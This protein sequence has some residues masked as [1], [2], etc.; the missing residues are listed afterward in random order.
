M[1]FQYTHRVLLPIFLSFF[2]SA[3]EQAKNSA[4]HTARELTGSNMVQQ[5]KAMENK[6]NAINEQQKERLHDLEQQ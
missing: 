5:K 1:N 2:L 6:L 3:C 4:D